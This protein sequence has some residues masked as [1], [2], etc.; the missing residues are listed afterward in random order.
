MSRKDDPRWF[1]VD[2]RFVRKLGRNITL[3]EL[4]EREELAG[5]SLLRRGNRLSVMPVSAEHWEFI[6]GLE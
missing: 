2:V 4:K 1:M 5:F 6:L 3:A